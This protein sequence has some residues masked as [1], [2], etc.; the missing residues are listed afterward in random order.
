MDKVAGVSRKPSEAVDRGIH[1][2]GP[3]LFEGIAM[4]ADDFVS[5]GVVDEP[6]GRV[7][8]V[9]VEDTLPSFQRELGAYKGVDT[10]EARAAKDAGVREVKFA[11]IKGGIG[12]VGGS[13]DHI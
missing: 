2:Y 13:L 12:D 7:K 4:S 3:S 1:G 8:S 6:R 5:G 9:A 10:N 11:S